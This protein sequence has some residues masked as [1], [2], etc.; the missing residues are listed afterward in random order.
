L[1][2]SHERGLSVATRAECRPGATFLRRRLGRED[3][4][5][6]REPIADNL[7]CTNEL[8]RQS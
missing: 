6:G 1:D 5:R 7:I 3:A 2:E 8:R 4:P